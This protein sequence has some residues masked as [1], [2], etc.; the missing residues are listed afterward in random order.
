MALKLK[1]LPRSV[2]KFKS[3]IRFPSSVNGTSGII[4]AKSGSVYTISLDLGFFTPVGSRYVNTTAPLAGGG[5]LSSDLTLSIIGAALTKTND[6]NVTMTFGGAPTTALLAA[7]SITLGW[8]GTLAVAR[9]GTGDSGTAWTAYTPTLSAGAGTFTSATV[10]AR[11]KTLGKTVFY[12]VQIV[13]TT[14]GTASSFIQ[15]TLAINPVT[16]SAYTASGFRS[17]GA[18]VAGNF[19]A[20]TINIFKYDGTYPGADG[21]TI[22]VSGIYESA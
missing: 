20:S 8:T 2:L 22:T 12:E 19:A 21:R 10:S 1:L 4:V 11:Y 14:N 3:D 16:A 18:L 15:A 9:G 13:I 6:T 7:T 5:P 17:D